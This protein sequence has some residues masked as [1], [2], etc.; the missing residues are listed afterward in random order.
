MQK[1]LCNLVLFA[2][3]V[4][5]L[6]Q[7]VPAFSLEC[8]DIKSPAINPKTGEC[9]TFLNTCEV[10]AD[11]QIVSICPEE[12]LNAFGLSQ[13]LPLITLIFGS[14]LGIGL[15]FLF[16][17]SGKNLFPFIGEK[18]ANLKETMQKSQER[19]KISENF[20]KMV[21]EKTPAVSEGTMQ[22][23]IRAE[24]KSITIPVL[25]IQKSPTVQNAER[26]ARYKDALEKLKELKENE[27]KIEKD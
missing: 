4:L 26:R 24:E 22:K 9:T 23:A 7:I 19:K 20:K 16:F 10:P 14:V 17:K 6:F 11:W 27:E 1:Y 13:F 2:M 21:H 12:D 3:A 18:I 15:L 5:F 8:L 25:Q